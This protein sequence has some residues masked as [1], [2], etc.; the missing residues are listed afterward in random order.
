MRKSLSF[1]KAI[2]WWTFAIGFLSGLLAFL[3]LLR[4]GN[5]AGDFTWSL[6]AAHNLLNGQNPYLA[7]TPAGA[8]PF[9]DYFYYPLPAALISIPFGFF[10]PYLAGAIFFGISSGILA[11]SMQ[12]QPWRLPVFLSAP[13][14]VS[15][16]VAQWGPLIMASAL[17]P[18]AFGAM[19]ILKPTLGLI[20]FSYRPTWK[21]IKI[22]LIIFVLS[23]VILPSWPLD[24]YQPSRHSVE[25][26]RYLIPLLSLGG[27][28]LILSI[29]RWR[30][31]EGRLLLVSSILPR[32]PYWYDGLLLWLIPKNLR[33]SLCLSLLSWIAYIGWWL[34]QTTRPP[35]PKAFFAMPWQVG[36]IYIPALVMILWPQHSSQ[37]ANSLELNQSEKKISKT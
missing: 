3:L 36:L 27:P 28:V 11:F 1:I 33:Q 31:P 35:D 26:G 20:S 13:F 30:T 12:S 37:T 15:A 14:F 2:K 22:G 10:S 17:L 34:V 19:A 29:L 8:Y 16:E 7:I 18:A 24:Y 21:A 32:N 4:S 5:L 25:S 6:R 23:L 9:D